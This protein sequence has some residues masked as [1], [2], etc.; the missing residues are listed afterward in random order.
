LEAR[1]TG[2]KLKLD[3][4]MSRHLR[5]VLEALGHDVLS[6]ADEGLL[7]QPD[8]IIADAA[9]AEGR[10]LLTLDVEFADLRKYPP[11]EHPGIILFRPH[12]FG[13]LGTNEMVRAFIESADLASLVGCVVVVEPGR[14]RI[15]R[16]ER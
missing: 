1:D 6:V 14:M 7:S 3:E 12:S 4:N 13:P 2:V 15:R 16:P 5:P 8:P 9:R 10:M 11:G